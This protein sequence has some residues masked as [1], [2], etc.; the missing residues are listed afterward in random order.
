MN[1][2]LHSSQQQKG[3]RRWLWSPLAVGSRVLRVVLVFLGKHR[4]VVPLRTTH[5]VK[6]CQCASKGVALMATN[7]S[8]RR[9][10]SRSSVLLV[11]LLTLV[12]ILSGCGASSPVV[13][14]HPSGSTPT[15]TPIQQLTGTISEFPLP[16]PHFYPGGI[17]RG[18]DGNLWFTEAVSN[19]CQS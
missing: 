10:R 7:L 18:P 1:A 17:M 16:A 14:S 6:E 19:A 3:S 11:S 2:H 15:S 9:S 13:P 8:P 5:D 4:S 12:G